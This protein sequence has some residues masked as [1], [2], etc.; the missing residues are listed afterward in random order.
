MNAASYIKTATSEKR[1]IRG[2][3]VLLQ[4]LQNIL[5]LIESVSGILAILKKEKEICN[6]VKF[7]DSMHIISLVIVCPR[8]HWGVWHTTTKRTHSS[9]WRMEWSTPSQQ[10]EQIIQNMPRIEWWKETILLLF[11]VGGVGCTVYTLCRP[12]IPGQRLA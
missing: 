4:L 6:R 1:N 9:I 10:N 12:L 7:A 3:N 8:L 2:N 11:L 5:P